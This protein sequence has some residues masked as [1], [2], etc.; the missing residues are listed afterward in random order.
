MHF[1]LI[2]RTLMWTIVNNILVSQDKFLDIDTDIDEAKSPTMLQIYNK[3]PLTRISFILIFFI[4][5][6]PL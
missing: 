3:L 2:F 5:S 4:L 6:V 1:K